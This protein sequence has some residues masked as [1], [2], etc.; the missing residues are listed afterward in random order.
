[1]E[2]SKK[3][4]FVEEMSGPPNFSLMGSYSPGLSGYA[5]ADFLDARDT[6]PSELM[7]DPTST[8]TTTPYIQIVTNASNR[9]LQEIKEKTV[10][11]VSGAGAWKKRL[12]DFLQQKNDEL[13][14]FLRKPLSAHPTLSQAEVFFRRFGIPTFTATHQSLR[15]V[16]LDASGS[17][18]IPKIE[19]ELLA[20]GPASPAKLT[21]EVRWLYDSYRKAGEEVMVNETT[22]RMKLELLDKMHQKALGIMDL[23]I[24]EH[25]LQL[26]EAGLQYLSVFFKEQ[27]IEENYKNYIESYRRFTALKEI[28]STFRFTD[29]IDKEPLCSICLNQ[30]VSYCLSPCGHTF[31]SSCIKRQ[32]SSCY[33]CRTPLRDRVRIYF[34]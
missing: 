20:I 33:I 3:N 9:Q 23:P 16:F 11:P 31:C 10:N 17:S 34:S 13:L 2:K 4:L 29:H 14:S 22:L 30:P 5:P 25:S 24:N 12:K 26:Q 28:I 15:E 19:E 8:G 6:T 1:M 18:L 7:L 32:M 21:E 27:Q